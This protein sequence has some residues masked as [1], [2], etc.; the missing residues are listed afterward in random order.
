MAR[1]NGMQLYFTPRSH[2]SRKVRIL[3]DALVLDAELVEAGVTCAGHNGRPGHR[4]ESF[5]LRQ[6]PSQVISPLGVL[7]ALLCTALLGACSEA[8]TAAAT[9]ATRDATAGIAAD[10]PAS[11]AGAALP[12]VVVYKT[13]TCGC[14][15][16]WVSHMKSAGFPVEVHDLDNLDAVKTR[17]GV[18][19]AKGSCHTAEVGG[20]FVEGHV[21]AADVKRLLVER[22]A[23]KGLTVPGMPAGSPGMEVPDGTVQPYDVELVAADGTTSVYAHHGP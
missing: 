22:P 9:A 2:F 23:A 15:G 14:C 10:A 4:Q 17:V 1:T 16:A 5:M 13:P 21:P 6:P 8:G 18:P 11:P 12:L 20:Y 7:S 19:F 3:L